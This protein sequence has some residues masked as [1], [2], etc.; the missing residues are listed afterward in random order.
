MRSFILAALLL[1]I[2]TACAPSG[3]EKYSM[4]DDE[5]HLTPEQG[6]GRRVYNVRCSHCH[7]AYV[8]K[9]RNGP[10]LK[11]LYRKPVMPS[12]T[13]A[14]DQRI[15]E[16]VVRGKRMMPPTALSDD[17]LAALLAYLKTL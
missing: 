8:D 4:T 3:E 15:A 13:P 5:L 9:G 12:G 10:T 6:A 16:V 14:N 11:G 2:L 7:E 1:L 17:Q